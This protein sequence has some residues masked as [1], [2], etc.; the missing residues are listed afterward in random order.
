MGVLCCN[1]ASSPR[2]KTNIQY[3]EII[4]KIIENK[5]YTKNELDLIMNKFIDQT[6]I[7]NGFYDY[8][9]NDE[10]FNSQKQYEKKE[11]NKVISFH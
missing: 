1:E 3:D 7:N 5:I 6:I 4:P 9:D 8:N 2:K 10:S 11:L